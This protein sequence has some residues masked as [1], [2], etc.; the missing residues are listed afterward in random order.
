[1]L[2]VTGVPRLGGGEDAPTVAPAAQ[3]QARWT[4]SLR[5]NETGVAVLGQDG[6]PVRGASVVLCQTGTPLV[7]LQSAKT[8]SDGLA[9]FDITAVGAGSYTVCVLAD[10][11]AATTEVLDLQARTTG[12]VHLQPGGDL[13]IELAGGD[14]AKFHGWMVVL[15]AFDANDAC[16]VAFGEALSAVDALDD[17]G[18]RRD[19]I[20]TDDGA[21][22][23]RVSVDGSAI[24]R[25]LPR[26]TVV[27]E[28]W[29]TDGG[30]GLQPAAGAR[31]YRT[32]YRLEDLAQVCRLPVASQRPIG[33]NVTVDGAPAPLGVQV[34][35]VC[36]SNA[37]EEAAGD[38]NG[39]HL[40]STDGHGYALYDEAQAG[41]GAM[42]AAYA[43]D[44]H[45][46]ARSA[47]TR[48]GSVSNIDVN[49]P[50]ESVPPLRV[51]CV[52]ASGT[53]LSPSH[54]EVLDA[55]QLAQSGP[56]HAR[57]WSSNGSGIECPVVFPSGT[58][59]V[60]ASIDPARHPGLRTHAIAQV[61]PGAEEAVVVFAGDASPAAAAG[62]VRLWCQG[63]ADGT[64]LSVVSHGCTQH[65]R[66]VE[67]A[68]GSVL[69]DGYQ[70]GTHAICVRTSDGRAGFADVEVS[71]QGTAR[72][73]AKLQPAAALHL[74]L[75]AGDRIVRW[76]IA[77]CDANGTPLLVL[78]QGADLPATGGV[79]VD[80]LPAVDV[81]VACTRQGDDR[82]ARTL[83]RTS[84]RAGSTISVQEGA[85]AASGTLELSWSASL[86]VKF[87][88][89]EVQAPGVNSA[90]V[91]AVMF[92]NTPVADEA[93]TIVLQALPPGMYKIVAYPYAGADEAVATTQVR[94]VEG[95]QR[96]RIGD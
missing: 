25:G 84:L 30:D 66:Q 6:Q 93:D 48:A 29:R 59:Q 56:A 35:L 14:E 65:E 8:A 85:G 45:R 75:A 24:W 22:M 54:V 47:V 95:S 62:S 55:Q 91:P 23:R 10:N 38:W 16:G 80:G 32:K 15:R 90:S 4:T 76:S 86:A 72:A 51:R 44:G 49:L 42:I 34:A 53:E 41:P 28:A 74:D 83:T 87:L 89:F 50:G 9:R 13:T 19:T 21:S 68:G 11:H 57:L 82:N 18:G 81:V 5:T 78:A 94:V 2:A 92:W 46:W 17:I 79:T 40:A 20:R 88:T 58:M 69:L 64:L 71:A 63:A 27:V 43:H 73:A 60:V 36:W 39:L 61:A 12:T 7:P 1:M 31:I 67:V 37:G 26:C 52:D 70:P 77:A 33:V 96:C 3:R